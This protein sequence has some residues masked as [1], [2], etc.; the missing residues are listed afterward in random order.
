MILLSLVF[1]D[2]TLSHILMYMRFNL[3]NY[4]NEWLRINRKIVFE[5]VVIDIENGD[6]IKIM[7]NP[8]LDY[9]EQ[10]MILVKIRNYI[11]CTCD[12]GLHT[13]L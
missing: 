2:D 12:Y 7:K 13:L 11:L 9:P 6:L 5:Q 4:K 1:T 10:F 8:N 3:D